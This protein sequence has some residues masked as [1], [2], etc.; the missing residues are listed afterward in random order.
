MS[1]IERTDLGK[2]I[3][4]LIDVE[5]PDEDETPIPGDTDEETPEEGDTDEETP[6][7]KGEEQ[8]EEPTELQKHGLDKKFKSTDEALAALGQAERTITQHQMERR[9]W[10]E[11]LAV[12]EG[13][14]ERAERPASQPIQ[15]DPDKF[16]DD[17]QA[18][19]ASL[20]YVRSDDV[21]RIA[22]EVAQDMMD[23]RQ[24]ND[25]AISKKDFEELRPVMDAVARQT[26]GIDQM[27]ASAAIEYLYFKARELTGKMDVQ[28][29]TVVTP[30]PGAAKKDIANTSGGSKGGP[31]KTKTGKSLDDYTPEELEK[32]PPAKI[33]ELL[34]YG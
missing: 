13:R 29:Q 34:G 15:I 10:E 16:V 6:E 22:A 31:P 5:P 12:M 8:K 17:P 27:S 28:P 24:A 20:G 1:D 19:I 9:A 30:A 23:R 26:R 11:R 14:L 18:A 33:K 2:H 4:D 25:F 7:T 21:Q 3:T 32:L